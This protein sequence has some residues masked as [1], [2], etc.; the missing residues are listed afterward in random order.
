MVPSLSTTPYLSSTRG[1][2][3]QTTRLSGPASSMLG[4]VRWSSQSLTAVVSASASATNSGSILRL[5]SASASPSR[6]F[7]ARSSSTTST[8]ATSSS[9]GNSRMASS[10]STESAG[11]S[12]FQSLSSTSTSSPILSSSK[13]TLTSA[14]TIASA[15]TA[16]LFISTTSTTSFS[17]SITPIASS[18]SSTINTDPVS[19]LS[20]RQKTVIASVVG[21]LGSVLIIAIIFFFFIRQRRRRHSDSHR[22]F[23]HSQPRYPPAA[24]QV[25]ST[26]RSHMTQTYAQ[27]Q[28]PPPTSSTQRSYPPSSSASDLSHP[29]FLGSFFTR[30]R[31]DTGA[32]HLSN[33]IQGMSSPSA[34]EQSGFMKISGRKLERWQD[35]ELASIHS[36]SGRIYDRDGR[37]IVRPVAGPSTLEDLRHDEEQDQSVGR[38]SSNESFG[39]DDGQYYYYVGT[40]TIPGASSNRPP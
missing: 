11:T 15:S 30:S 37:E 31:R 32:S 26:P 8:A 29:R 27:A 21:S 2:V 23:T 20:S 5:S 40:S 3:S 9:I 1:S 34:V 39:A 7:V 12:L 4:T 14:S 24:A 35:P 22:I 19:Q 17:S 10:S 36:L 16:S 25:T 6:I 38:R 13:L 28:T 33:S 18:A